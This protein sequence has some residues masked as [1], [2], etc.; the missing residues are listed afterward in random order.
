MLKIGDFAKQAQVSV[1][2]LRHYSKLGLLKPTWIDRFTGYRYYT[3]EQLQ[4]LK[5]ILALKDLGFSLE[6]VKFVLQDNLS[7]DELRGM[8][9]IKQA[10]LARHIQTEQARLARV[11][12]YLR[13]LEQAEE[14][15]ILPIHVQH[16]EKIEMEPTFET[17]AAFTVVGMKY[18]G[19]NQNNEIPQMWQT[20]FPRMKE[21]THK[22]NPNV[23]YG[24]CGALDDD[25]VFE[26]LAGFEVANTDDIPEGM[27][28][29]DVPEQTY[30]IFP[31]TLKTIHQTYEYIFKTWL[32][33]SDYEHG[34]GPDFE[35]YGEDFDR[36][37]EKL[38]IYM[39]VKSSAV[40]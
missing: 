17:K 5:R 31:C 16:K 40:A 9:K 7:V 26:Y 6:Q 32:P 27:I 14:S 25:G 38:Y 33:Q 29:W 34:G 23:N 22:A 11:E 28:S 15:S 30:A 8:L 36:E 19:K 35:F 4:Q 1:K 37:E 2:T 20:F 12:T 3:L 13:Q 10:E 39:P 24:V 18:R 21:I